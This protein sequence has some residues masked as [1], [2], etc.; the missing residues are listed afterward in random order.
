MSAPGWLLIA[1]FARRC[2]LPVSTLRYYDRV[3]L[4]RPAEVDARSGYRRY[5]VDQLPTAVTIARLR[6]IGTSPETIARILGGGPGAVAALAAERGRITDEIARRTAAL[7][8]LDELVGGRPPALGRPCRVGLA[9][10]RV[11]VLAFEAGVADLA[12]AVTRGVAGLR[13][14]L[15]RADLRVQGW[16]ALLPLDLGDRVT[17]HV[18]ARTGLAPIPGGVDTFTLPDGQG[19]RVDHDGDPDQLAHAY[20]AVLTEIDRLGARPAAHVIEDYG[21]LAVRVTV[22]LR[23]GG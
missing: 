2:R 10:D 17:G 22:P 9:A 23:P 7:S 16:G 13:A 1:E 14:R 19:V 3:G 20:H 11:P 18:F 12:A 15:R 6:S 8:R 21:P 5:T 4:L